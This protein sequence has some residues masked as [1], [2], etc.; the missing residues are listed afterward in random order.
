MYSRPEFL[1]VEGGYLRPKS[2]EQIDQEVKLGL[3][4]DR[5]RQVVPLPTLDD[6][7]SDD[8]PYDPAKPNDY[9][10][11]CRELAK[12]KTRQQQVAREHAAQQSKAEATARLHA[13]QAEAIA[14][15]ESQ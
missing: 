7:S 5:V 12:R 8:E 11:Y 15:V 2:Q 1:R 4:S 14:F 3:I 10:K 13:Q 6:D 9:E